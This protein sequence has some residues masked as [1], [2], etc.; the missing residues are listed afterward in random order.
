MTYNRTL[1]PILI[2]QADFDGV[3]Q[4]AK[5]CDWEQLQIFIREQQV[6][7][8]L[9]KIGNCLYEM[10][11]RY[12]QGWCVSGTYEGNDI[13]KHLFCGG[14]YIACDGTVKMH[15]GFKRS[16]VYWAY[17]AYVYR[18]GMVDTPF[19]VVQK[20]NQD[21]I[22]VDVKELGRLNNEF[23]SNAE[24]FYRLS[25]DYLC[26]VKDKEP[27]SNCNVCSC[28]TDCRCSHCD[29]KGATLQRRGVRFK[30]VYK[31]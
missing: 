18:H 7:S 24:Y 15:F 8:L 13:I 26:S 25:L 3:V 31:D 10:F 27:I 9:P 11:V 22:P 5:H 14:R 20:V 2:D 17:G 23:R 12:D 6:L 19:G 29:G 21:S 30:T 4:V 16:L 1:E 28:I